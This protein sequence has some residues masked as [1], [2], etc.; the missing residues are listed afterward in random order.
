MFDLHGR[1]A[2]ITG[3]SAGLGVQMSKALARQ[4]ADLAIM[5]RREELLNEVAEE[6]RKL[7]VRCLVVPC[8]V[9]DN[10]SVV[11][12]RDK[13]LAEYGK[14]DILVNNAGG[15]KGA[16]AEDMPDD[17]WE[18]TINLSLNSL[19]Y[20][21][22]AFGKVML[23]AGY[24]RVINIASMM[25]LVGN[26]VIPSSGYEAAKGGAINYTRALAAEWA[27]RGVTVNAICPGFI[28]GSTNAGLWD[29]PFFQEFIK[30]YIPMQRTG[31]EG[32]LDSSVVFLAA[33]ESSFV[34]GAI[35][36][37]D[38]GLTCI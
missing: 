38:G 9:T 34:T 15:G 19:F 14:V 16:P 36:S 11:A 21:C 25:G 1:V 12:A 13:I 6:V 3:A 17:K 4:G 18:Y 26:F 35:L 33:D 5:A 24:G 10:D 31:V 29:K 37:V 28:P 23:E 8:D 27:S 30:N 2:V 22:R 20:V 7:G 32:E